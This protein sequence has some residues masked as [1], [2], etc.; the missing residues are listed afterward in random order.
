MLIATCDSVN[1]VEFET[2]A[3]QKAG[4]VVDVVVCRQVA[5]WGYTSARVSGGH[6][7]LAAAKY[8]LIDDGY[9]VLLG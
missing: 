8:E 4:M 9:T 1:T 2:E 3:G 6:A 5:N 7:W